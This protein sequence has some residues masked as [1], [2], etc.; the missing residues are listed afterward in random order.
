M[1][2]K[3]TDGVIPVDVGGAF[4]WVVGDDDQGT[5]VARRDGDDLVKI[6]R[7]TQFDEN[8]DPVLVFVWDGPKEIDADTKKSLAAVVARLL[9][10]RG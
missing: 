5:Y 10:A 4:S 6:A 1:T 3:R 9:L 7:V 8:C 2:E